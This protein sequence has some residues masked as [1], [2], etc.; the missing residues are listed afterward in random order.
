[1]GMGAMEVRKSCLD[2]AH[3]RETGWRSDASERLA[4][5][6]LSPGFRGE[7]RKMKKSCEQK[8]GRLASP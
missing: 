2:S 7:T 5:F 8:K 1:V 6:A 4:G 3:K